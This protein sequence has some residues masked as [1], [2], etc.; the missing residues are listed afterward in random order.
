MRL[1]GYALEPGSADHQELGCPIQQL[2]REVVAGGVQPGMHVHF[3][4]EGVVLQVIG[5]NE[6]EVGDSPT[7]VDALKSGEALWPVAP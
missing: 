4:D 6:L 2:R 5:G 1:V 7:V 3:F